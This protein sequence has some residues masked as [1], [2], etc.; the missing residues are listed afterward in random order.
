MALVLRFR[1]PIRLVPISV[2]AQERVYDL[3]QGKYRK[4]QLRLFDIA[5]DNNANRVV[6]PCEAAFT[7]QLL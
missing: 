4:R 1:T 6:L 3:L 7:A 2:A 5:I